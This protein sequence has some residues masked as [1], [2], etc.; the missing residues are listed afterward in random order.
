MVMKK[1]ILIL[2][3]SILV[4]TFVMGADNATEATNF[5]DFDVDH[6]DDIKLSFAKFSGYKVQVR[7]GTT[8][9]FPV[10]DKEG[11]I[12]NEMLI[13]EINGDF[14]RI[15]L[16]LNGGPF[17][18]YYLE[19]GNEEQFNLT[20]TAPFILVKEWVLHNSDSNVDR[21]IILEFR[22]P[23]LAYS[24][25]PDLTKGVPHV[26]I[27]SPGTKEND[28]DYGQITDEDPYTKWLLIIVIALLVVLVLLGP[29]KK[30]FFKKK[31]VKKD[32]KK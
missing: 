32:S 4:S 12:D 25:N 22:Y 18:T 15:Q 16:R 2:L 8:I 27:T 3:M 30:R 7:E 5:Y 14:T 23:F 21:S 10:L 19:L 17:E 26:E 29:A 28:T 20:E 1:I 24:N 13:E 6:G 31:T 9:E 11:W